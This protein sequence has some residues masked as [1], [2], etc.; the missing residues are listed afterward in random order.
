MAQKLFFTECSPIL[1][2]PLKKQKSKECKEKQHELEHVHCVC[3]DRQINIHLKTVEIAYLQE[4][5]GS[6]KITPYLTTLFEK[7]VRFRTNQNNFD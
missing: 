4:K 6:F 5:I 1:F 2:Q 3:F 7:F